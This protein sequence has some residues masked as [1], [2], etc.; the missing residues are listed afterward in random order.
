M[1]EHGQTACPTRCQTTVFEGKQPT[2]ADWASGSGQLL[3]LLEE[4]ELCQATSALDLLC[5]FS[6]QKV[7]VW[8]RAVRK[9]L[10]QEQ[11]DG[12]GLGPGSPGSA[13]SMQLAGNLPQGHEKR[14]CFS[15]VQI[16]QL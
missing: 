12:A 16:K 5:S 15:P 10:G 1:G 2:G 6:V 8:S 7:P 11:Q 3:Q 4:L 9:Q 14:R 13:P